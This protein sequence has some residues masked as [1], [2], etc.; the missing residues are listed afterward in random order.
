MH[1][2]T[3]AP[4]AG[5]SL[6]LPGVGEEEFSAGI[7]CEGW[8]RVG[9]IAARFALKRW[10][11]ESSIQVRLMD[12]ARPGRTKFSCERVTASVSKA[13]NKAADSGRNFSKSKVLLSFCNESYGPQH[14]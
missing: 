9:P 3:A 12:S 13:R 14:H 4:E 8:C 6:A 1:P 2:F 10:G 11:Y 5:F 7:G